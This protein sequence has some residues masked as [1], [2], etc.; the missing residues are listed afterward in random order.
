MRVSNTKKPDPRITAPMVLVNWIRHR[1]GKSYEDIS[2]ILEHKHRS[3][4]N[5]FSCFRAQDEDGDWNNSTDPIQMSSECFLWNW[6]SDA[7]E[8]L[9]RRLKKVYQSTNR[10]EIQSIIDEISGSGGG[11]TDAEAALWA[12]DVKSRRRV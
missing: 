6:Q 3:S 5:R 7:C 1:R 8:Y 12:R 4:V 11:I 2:K 10:D 9:K